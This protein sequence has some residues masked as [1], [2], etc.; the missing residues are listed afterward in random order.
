MYIYLH[1]K[2]WGDTA[3]LQSMFILVGDWGMCRSTFVEKIR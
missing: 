1:A 2:Q 3:Y